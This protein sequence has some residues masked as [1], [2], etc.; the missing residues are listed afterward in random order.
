MLALLTYVLV[1]IPDVRIARAALG[2]ARAPP[3]L[4]HQGPTGSRKP[5]SDDDAGSVPPTCGVGDGHI[6]TDT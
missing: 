6:P 2:V 5:G 4:D 3:G 1:R